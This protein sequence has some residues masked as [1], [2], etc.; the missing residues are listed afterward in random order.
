MPPGTSPIARAAGVNEQDLA[1]LDGPAPDPGRAPSD[2][3]LLADR[4]LDDPTVALMREQLSPPEN[5]GTVVAVDCYRMTSGL[6]N[7]VAFGIDSRGERSAPVI[8][9]D[10]LNTWPRSASHAARPGRTEGIRKCHR[11]PVS[12]GRCRRPPGGRLRSRTDQS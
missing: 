10:M 9:H 12:A 5:V 4:A 6:P 3:V 8:G 11:V 1:S 7:S 2:T